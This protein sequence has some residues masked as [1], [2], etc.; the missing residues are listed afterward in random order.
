MQNLELVS[1]VERSKIVYIHSEV[2][3]SS[4]S[5]IIASAEKKARFHSVPLKMIT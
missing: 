4:T 1:N 3:S 5:E 2:R